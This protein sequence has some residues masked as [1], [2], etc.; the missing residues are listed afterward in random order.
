MLSRLERARRYALLRSNSSSRMRYAI[1]I[2]ALLL[3]PTR[4][5]TR[6][7]PP[8]LRACS[9]KS[10]HWSNVRRMPAMP[11]SAMLSMSSTA[12]D[13]SRSSSQSEL[14][15][16]AG[17]REKGLESEKGAWR[18]GVSADSPIET[19]WVMPSCLSMSAFEAWFRFPRYCVRG[20]A[21]WH[22]DLEDDD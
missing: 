21:F 2:V 10:R 11:S 7:L 4:Q 18:G 20:L 8:A 22:L 3:T 14:V 15:G 12:I 6:T 1:T 13:P 9:I 5:C 17:V 16:R 19:T